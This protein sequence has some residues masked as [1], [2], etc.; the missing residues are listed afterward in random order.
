MHL[1]IQIL[2]SP[3]GSV[4]G[5]ELDQVVQKESAQEDAGL[6]RRGGRE[7][8]AHLI[9]E[10]ISIQW[11]VI[12]HSSRLTWCCT[13]LCEAAGPHMAKGILRCSL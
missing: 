12:H 7:R 9:T 3:S 5:G 2:V 1:F 10:H 4:L 11:N 8:A 6:G 13:T